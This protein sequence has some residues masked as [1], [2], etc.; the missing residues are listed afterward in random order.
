MNNTVTENLWNKVI[1]K[2]KAFQEKQKGGPLFFK[3][4]MNQLLSNT[5]AAVK[6]LVEQ[7]KKNNI[8]IVQGSEVMKVTSQIAS[9]INRLKHVG[10]FPQEMSTTLLTIMQTSLASECKKVFAA[11]EVQNIFDDLNHLRICTLRVLS[12]RLNISFL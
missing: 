9:S 4:V 5:E 2:Y 7:V 11:I 8:G 12:I 1:E 10:K 3:L 6:A